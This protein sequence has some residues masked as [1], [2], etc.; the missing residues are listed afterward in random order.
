M[1]SVA[2]LAHEA[3]LQ[4]VA[5]SAIAH[6]SVMRARRL[7]WGQWPG[8]PQSWRAPAHQ[9]PATAA[10][11]RPCETGTSWRGEA[12]VLVGTRAGRNS[13][14]LHS[15]I[16]LRAQSQLAATSVPGCECSCRPAVGP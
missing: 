2:C 10:T 12:V 11:P 13:N 6:P 5:L 16:A 8:G 3:H 7:S 15:F 9:G 14:T 4:L 1:P